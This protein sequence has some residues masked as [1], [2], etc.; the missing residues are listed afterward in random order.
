MLC[1]ASGSENLRFLVGDVVKV[2]AAL[3]PCGI[4]LLGRRVLNREDKGGLILQ[5]PRG[6]KLNYECMVKIGLRQSSSI[7]LCNKK[8]GA[9][10]AI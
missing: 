5:D 10:A 4:R 1:E 2:K 7:D 9:E 6:R 8:L 3:F